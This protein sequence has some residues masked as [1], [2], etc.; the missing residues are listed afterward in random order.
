MRHDLNMPCSYLFYICFTSFLFYSSILSFKWI[1]SS[2]PFLSFFFFSFHYSFKHLF[3]ARLFCSCDSPGKNTGV[4]CH[5]LLQRIFLTQGL[6][7]GPIWLSDL[8]KMFIR[9]CEAL[10]SN[11]KPCSF[12]KLSWVFFFHAHWESWFNPA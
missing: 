11:P 6:N 7:P 9:Q 5:S 10:D 8:H 12:L 2:A 3:S 4:G 1:F